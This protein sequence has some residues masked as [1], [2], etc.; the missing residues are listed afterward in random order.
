MQIAEQVIF[1]PYYQNAN[2]WNYTRFQ[3]VG[4]WQTFE[5]TIL[6]RVISASQYS[7]RLH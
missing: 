5:S 1:Q 6:C 4:P 2:E 3:L 7:F